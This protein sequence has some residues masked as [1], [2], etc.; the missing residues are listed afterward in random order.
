[1]FRRN[2]RVIFVLALIWI[3]GVIVYV[4]RDRG[5]GSGADADDNK[6]NKGLILK[7]FIPG[8]GLLIGWIFLAD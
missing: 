1:M 4:Y 5:G 6:L 3:V 7:N 2:T 8:G